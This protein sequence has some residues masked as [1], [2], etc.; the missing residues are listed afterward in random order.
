MV[1]DIPNVGSKSRYSFDVHISCIATSFLSGAIVLIFA[2]H[3][4]NSVLIT[5]LFCLLKS[6][7]VSH[8]V[9]RWCCFLLIQIQLELASN[10]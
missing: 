6:Y 5:T 4:S 1:S 3:P 9:I 10:D 2:S 7:G 8:I